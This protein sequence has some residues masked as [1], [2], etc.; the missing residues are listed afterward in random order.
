MRFYFQILWFAPMKDLSEHNFYGNV[1][2]TLNMMRIVN[3]FGSKMY[4]IDSFVYKTH[5]ATRL[6]LTKRD[7]DYTFKP[8][9]LYEE[10]SPLKRHR[11]RHA[12]TCYSKYSPVHPHEVEVA[13][14]VDIEDCRWLYRE[15]KVAV[16]NHICANT[17]KPR[18][19]S[20]RPHQCHRFNYFGVECPFDYDEFSAGVVL[21]SHYPE[22]VAS[23]ESEY[24]DEDEYNV[25]DEHYNDNVNYIYSVY[26]RELN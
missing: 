1:S 11:W 4:Y 21:R 20:F 8:V 15:C 7:Y 17:K 5:T 3:H 25:K 19:N 12:S 13:I 9:D 16:N 22:L 2:F 23:D 24:S 18:T 26:E 6:L 10:G 14:E